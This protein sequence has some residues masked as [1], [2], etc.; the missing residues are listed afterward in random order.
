M[1]SALHALCLAA[2]CLA[3]LGLRVD[4][5]TATPKPCPRGLCYS[6]YRDKVR[7]FLNGTHSS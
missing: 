5:R 4:V 3:T 2:L 6:H 7:G 1:R